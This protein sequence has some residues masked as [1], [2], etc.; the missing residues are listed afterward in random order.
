MLELLE[1]GMINTHK[2]LILSAFKDGES[3]RT[4]DPEEE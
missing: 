2:N 1:N 3:L 4:L